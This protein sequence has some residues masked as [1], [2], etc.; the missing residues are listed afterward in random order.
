MR[1]GQIC[2]LRRNRK[3]KENHQVLVRMTGGKGRHV[4]QNG[5]VMRRGRE[6]KAVEDVLNLIG[7]PTLQKKILSP[8]WTPV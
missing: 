4:N 3:N 1:T 7:E 6:K 2:D 5:R 8:S